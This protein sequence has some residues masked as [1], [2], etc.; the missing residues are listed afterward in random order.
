MIVEVFIVIWISVRLSRTPVN[1]FKS[2]CHSGCSTCERWSGVSSASICVGSLCCTG[3]N[4]VA[5]P[6]HTLPVRVWSTIASIC[7]LSR[8]SCRGAVPVSCN[9]PIWRA[10]ED[11][12]E[13]MDDVLMQSKTRCDDLRCL[14]CLFRDAFAYLLGS[15]VYCS[16]VIAFHMTRVL[17]DYVCPPSSLR[18]DRRI[19]PV[20]LFVK[21]LIHQIFP[22]NATEISKRSL[23]SP[24]LYMKMRGYY[25][26]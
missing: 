6:Y 14:S 10:L 13:A 8:R 7:T 26:T 24:A 20:D 12:Q 22:P 16:C 2:S 1:P 23:L 17:L 25:Y 4:C 9:N 5:D 18:H 3:G 11:L 15:N 21:L 19:D